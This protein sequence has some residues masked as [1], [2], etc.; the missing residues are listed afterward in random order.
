[1]LKVHYIGFL[2]NLFNFGLIQLKRQFC[3]VI[4]LVYFGL[5]T[6]WPDEEKLRFIFAGFE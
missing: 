2:K 4:K 3:I 6:L 1:M 5:L